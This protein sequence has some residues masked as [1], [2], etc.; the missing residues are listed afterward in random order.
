MLKPNFY[1]I[2][3]AKCATTTL[4]ALLMAHPEAEI[5]KGKEP[6]FFSIK[7]DTSSALEEYLSM[8]AHC[9]NEIAI[10][11]A[12]TSYSR[13]R[14]NPDT[15]KRIYKFTPDAKIIFMIRHPLKRIESAYA[16]RILTPNISH[17]PSLSES[18]HQIP[19]MVDS[20]RYWEVFD[21]Y[22]QI[23][24]EKN[25]KIVWFEE[26]IK[27]QSKV[28]ATICQFL[29]IS[30]DAI[31]ASNSKHLNS[32]VDKEKRRS[33]QGISLDNFDS[34]WEV[35][36]KAKVIDQLRDDNLKILRYFGKGDDFWGDI[37][38][39]PKSIQDPLI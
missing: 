32:R 11:D 2:G 6:H 33:D 27:D 20:S 1:I 13:I 26:F 18:V 9:S 37:F 28:F 24:P 34:K 38:T 25:I 22:R 8:Y 7:P 23:F 16:E 39:T 36:T 4:A 29:G 10:G 15:I 31:I 12:S 5:V 17:R 3:A 30:D 21:A 19:M 14:K 35:E